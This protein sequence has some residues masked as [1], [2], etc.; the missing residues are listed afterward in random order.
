MAR[1]I[2]LEGGGEEGDSRKRMKETLTSHPESDEQGVRA[3]HFI[4]GP[5]KECRRKKEEQE[6]GRT[7]VVGIATRKESTRNAKYYSAQ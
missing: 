6:E 7:V 2:G 3:G 5:S 4:L 1:K